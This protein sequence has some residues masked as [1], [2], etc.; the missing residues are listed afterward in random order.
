MYLSA[1]EFKL[2][3]Y[4]VSQRQQIVSREQILRDIWKRNNVTDRSVD[5]HIAILRKKLVGF[6]HDIRTV[7]GE[8]YLLLPHS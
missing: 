4:L 1:L 6:D 3:R 2:I 5:T 8:G 7:Y